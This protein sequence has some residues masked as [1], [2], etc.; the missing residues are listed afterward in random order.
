VAELDLLPY[1]EYVAQLPSKRMSAGVL[2]RD[3][4]GRVL[5]VEPSY[6]DY[7]EIPGGVVEH[8]EAPWTTALRELHEEIGLHRPPGQLLV[9]D[10][11]P[12]END[13]LPE[14]VA[15]IFDGGQVDETDLAD[16]VL[17]SEIVSARLCSA[18]QFRIK[19]P[20][21]LGDRLAAAIEAAQSGRT[22]LCEQGKRVL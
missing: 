4:R 2:I 5:L 14:R 21:L 22:V 19:V 20:P 9:V 18:E 11:V 15:F 3:D 16:L 12:P 6:K 17:G 13:T 7:W 1:D 8:G 10:H